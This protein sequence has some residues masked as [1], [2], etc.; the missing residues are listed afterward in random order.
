MSQQH[1]L[2][3][4]ATGSVAVKI[5]DKEVFY[6][7]FLSFDRSL[8]T[9]P[10]P[11]VEILTEKITHNTLKFMLSMFLSV[12]MKRY[13][14]TTCSVPLLCITDC[15][16]PII[17]SRI[18]ASNNETLEQYIFRSFQIVSGNATNDTLPI[19]ICKTFVT[20]SLCHS[21]TQSLCHSVTLS[22]CH[23][24]KAFCRKIDQLFKKEKNVY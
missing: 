15:S 7:A 17:K 1:C 11:H 19:K 4:D 16:W 3:V 5:N 18:G 14:Y 21:V 2:V 9:E 22:L 12:E 8:K 6:F 13:N 24:M 23:S 10:V 20:Q